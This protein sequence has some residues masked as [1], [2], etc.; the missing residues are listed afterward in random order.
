MVA[1]ITG[2]IIGSELIPAKEWKVLLKRYFNKIGR[3]PVTWEI[4]RG[5]TFQ[6]LIRK[7]EQ[8]LQKAIL[9]KSIVRQINGLDVRLSIGLGEISYKAKKITESQGSAFTHSGRKFD[10]LKSQGVNLV[11]TSDDEE[12]DN[13]MN[14]I[15]RLALTIMDNWS[16]VAAEIVQYF[17]ERPDKNQSEVAAALQINQSAVSQRRKRAQY[18]LLSEVIDFFETYIKPEKP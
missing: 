6:L 17:L 12:M 15:L 8:A 13:M 5:D 9:L 2:D 14:L 18:D 10:T 3:S 1:V 4:Y 7:P 11:I 16:P